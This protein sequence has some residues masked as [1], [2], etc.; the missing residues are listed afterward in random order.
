LLTS[1]TTASDCYGKPIKGVACQDVY[2][3]VCGCNGVTYPNAC[4]A[5]IAGI[6]QFT[7]GGCNGE[8]GAVRNK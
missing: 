3:P 1:G 7:Q 2:A 8:G 4:E 5:W 6:K